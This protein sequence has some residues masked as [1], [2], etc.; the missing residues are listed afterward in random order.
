MK[1]A[2]RFETEGLG[3]AWLNGVRSEWVSNTTSG[4]DIRLLLMLWARL[5]ADHRNAQPSV[6]E[7]I[8]L[9]RV[10]QLNARAS[11]SR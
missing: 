9:S 1:E 7:L 4:E 10:I 5:A 3:E 6:H 2:R 8:E 11:A